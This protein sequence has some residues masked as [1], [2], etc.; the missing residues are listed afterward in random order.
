[1]KY[2]LLLLTT[3]FCAMAFF[4]GAKECTPGDPGAGGENKKNDIAGGVLHADSKKPITNVSVTAYSSSKKEKMVLTDSNGNYYFNELKPGT[5]RLVFEKSGFRKV[6]R[7]KVMIKSDE[8]C[9]LNIEMDEEGDFQIMPSQLFF[10][11]E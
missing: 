11:L 1:M 4:A 9:Q 5:Y 2:K 3:V 7:D 6:T 10:D 8:G